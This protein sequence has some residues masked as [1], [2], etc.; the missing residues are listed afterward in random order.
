[1]KKRNLSVLLTVAT[2]VSVIAGCGN[3]GSNAGIQTDT[4]KEK[5]TVA[6]EATTAGNGKEITGEKTKLKLALWDYDVEGSV[7]PD[8]SI[9]SEVSG[10]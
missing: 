10:Y 8:G 9:R 6:S 2:V 7:Y 4:A 5:E 3:S 1:M